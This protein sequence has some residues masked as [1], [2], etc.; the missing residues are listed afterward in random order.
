[1]PTLSEMKIEQL[2]VNDRVQDA[3]GLMGRIVVAAGHSV[4]LLWDE[5]MTRQTIDIGSGEAM[6]ILYL[7]VMPAPESHS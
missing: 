6:Q 3:K 7:G 1:M 4:T 5:T 2:H